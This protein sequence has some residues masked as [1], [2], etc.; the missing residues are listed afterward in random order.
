MEEVDNYLQIM[1]AFNDSIISF[2]D[3]QSDDKSALDEISKLIEESKIVNDLLMFK[4]LLH[5]IINIFSNYHYP[6]SSFDKIQDILLPIKDDIIRLLPNDT[7]FNIVK[8]HKRI[9]LF[10]FENK[11]INMIQ[12]LAVSLM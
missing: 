11:I 10:F 8:D 12:Y 4:S 2:I 3:S 1:K 9:L 7:I 5:L 6:P